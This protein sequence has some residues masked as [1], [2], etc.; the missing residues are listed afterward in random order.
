MSFM[1]QGA[2]AFNQPLN[3]WNV[4]NVAF[5]FSMFFNAFL[6]NR[7]I[8]DWNTSRVINMSAMF[9]GARDFN[10]NISNWNTSNVTDMSI[11]F[12]DA[13]NFNNGMPPI[14]NS[15]NRLT[16]NVSNVIPSGFDSMFNGASSF[17]TDISDWDVRNVNDNSPA[18]G[19]R[20]NSP[21]I[22]NFTPPAIRNAPGRGQ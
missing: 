4:S 19:F 6:F 14:P 12:W 9:A 10:Q 18:V 20:L 7:P 17:N 15:S 1:F 11:M 22:D 21:L 2:T 13:I 3:N 8:S 5:M 16:W